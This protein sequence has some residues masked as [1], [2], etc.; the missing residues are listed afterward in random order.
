MDSQRHIRTLRNSFSLVGLSQLDAR[1][2]EAL[3]FVHAILKGVSSDER[4]TK[5]PELTANGLFKSKK[6][7]TDF[8]CAP[9]FMDGWPKPRYDPAAPRRVNTKSSRSHQA[10][11][12]AAAAASDSEEE[13][14]EEHTSLA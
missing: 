12:A 6:F 13:G 7:P 4:P 11:S 10:R 5:C 8:F 3:G 2:Q 1:N 9:V 14:E